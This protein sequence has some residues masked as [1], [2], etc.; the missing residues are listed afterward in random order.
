MSWKSIG[1]IASLGAFGGAQSIWNDFTG[2]SAAD[3]QLQAQ[4]EANEANIRLWQMQADYNTPAN[5]VARY[6]E[7]GLNPNLIYGQGS[8]SAGNMSTAPRVEPEVRYQ[9]SWTQALEK[10]SQILSIRNMLAQNKNLNAQTGNIESQTRA[11]D[12]HTA[13]ENA[14]VDFYNTH[15]FFPGQTNAPVNM[16]KSPE[17]QAVAGAGG[18][19][20]G[21]IVGATSNFLNQNV[22]YQGRAEEMARKAANKRGLKGKER[23]AYITRFMMYYLESH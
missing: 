20:V 21:N 18:K 8:S 7:A 23:E 22:D 2:K 14:V 15:G 11:H 1:N 9:R 5:Q 16:V 10:A 4:R 13:Y 12:A 3:A 6:R 17:I 19:L